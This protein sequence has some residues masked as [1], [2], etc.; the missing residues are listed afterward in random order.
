MPKFPFIAAALLALALPASA[1]SMSAT[2]RLGGGKTVIVNAAKSAEGTAYIEVALPEGTQKIEGL[3]DRFMP[4]KSNGRE[5]TLIA[6]DIN[7]D[8]VDE[9]I[10]RAAITSTAS[11][12]LVYQWDAEQKQFFPVLFTDSQDEDKPFL[13]T[14]QNSTVSVEK[15]MIVVNVT[16]VDQSGRSARIVERYNWDG[17]GIKYFEDH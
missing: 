8:G 17:D 2:A 7:G 9:I 13:F 11:A 10:A 5:T 14:D 3:G 4:L 16:R 6:A 1:Q 12:L 15:N